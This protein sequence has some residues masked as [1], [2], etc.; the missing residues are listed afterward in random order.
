MHQKLC[1]VKKNG[2]SL[3]RRQHQL[4]EMLYAKQMLKAGT[5][6]RKSEVGPRAVPAPSQG[7]L[8]QGHGLP[9]WRV[10]QASPSPGIPVG[11]SVL[12]R[13]PG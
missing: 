12:R 1:G 5:E 13:V 7:E 6:R 2:P 3:L 11:S 9:L 4:E 8:R 10:C